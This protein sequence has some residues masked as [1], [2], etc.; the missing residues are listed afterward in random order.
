MNNSAT[1][2]AHVIERQSKQ[3]KI[4]QKIFWADLLGLT[5]QFWAILSNFEE[6]WTI[7]SNFEQFWGVWNKENISNVE[8]FFN[9]FDHFEQFWT[10]LNNFEQFW[11]ILTNFEQFFGGENQHNNTHNA[12]KTHTKRTKR[13][14]GDEKWPN[15]QWKL[16]TFICIYLGPKKIQ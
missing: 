4:A 16:S 12:H 8:Q 14:T 11:A 7:L 10:I 1:W 3:H 15:S 9:N 5:V 13:T 2:V 6:F